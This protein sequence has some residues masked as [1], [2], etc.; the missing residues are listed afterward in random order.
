ML[1][2]LIRIPLGVLIFF[3]GSTLLF[4]LMMLGVGRKDRVL[5]YTSRISPLML[6]VL[7]IRVE[8]RNRQRLTESMPCVFVGNHQHTFDIFVHGFIMP[9]DTVTIGKTAVR[10]IPVFGWIFVLSGNILLDREKH[11][12][13]LASMALAAREMI[14]RKKSIWI[15]PEGT[16]SGKRGLLPFKKGAFNLA[17]EAKRPMVPVVTSSYFK[18]LDLKKWNAGTVIVEVLEPVH[19]ERFQLAEVPRLAAEVHQ[20]MLQKLTLLDAEVLARKT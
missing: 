11:D 6:R 2:F 9:R 15:F 12:S 5:F 1:L 18:A 14:A 3:I 20:N 16:R 13:A 19:T 10:Y 17:V 4:L 8:L 7:G